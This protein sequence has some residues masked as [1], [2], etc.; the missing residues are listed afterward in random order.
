MN[1]RSAAVLLSVAYFAASALGQ[2]AKPTA[3][4]ASGAK[5]TA[6]AKP[7]KATKPAKTIK[8]VTLE[9]HNEGSVEGAI[10]GNENL[11][12]LTID[13]A[14]LHYQRKGEEKP[15]TVTWDQLSGW[16]PNNFTSRSPSRTSVTG[17]DYGIGIY[18]GSR[19]ISLR[20]RSGRDYLAALKALRTMAAPK[21][22]PGIG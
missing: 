1:S 18:L 16:Q 3:V 12:T 8:P 10:Y 6:A 20:T 5:S 11:V 17:G 21:E 15:T 22:R 2:T 14:G 4:A 7:T 9:V 13:S 19:Y